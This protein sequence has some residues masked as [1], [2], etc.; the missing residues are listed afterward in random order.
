VSH[1]VVCRRGERASENEPYPPDA[2][3]S[4][5][6]I[7]QEAESRIHERLAVSLRAKVQAARTAVQVAT[8]TLMEHEHDAR[9]PMRPRPKTAAT[10][11]EAATNAQI[12][13]ELQIQNARGD[14]AELDAEATL[15]VL[16]R[17]EARGDRALAFAAEQRVRRLVA[18][19]VPAPETLTGNPTDAAERVRGPAAATAPATSN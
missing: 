17:A 11:R 12:L 1:R 9:Q 10:T 15:A 13:I 8:D 4:A 16:E 14:V 6:D 3:R 2:R 18:T 5:G 7:E 19:L